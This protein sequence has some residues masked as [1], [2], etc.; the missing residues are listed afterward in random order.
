M[1]K[2]GGGYEGFCVDVLKEL[3]KSLSNFRYNISEL[4][5]QKVGQ[6]GKTSVWDD[7]ITELK[8]GVSTTLN[9]LKYGPP[10]IRL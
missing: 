8:V 10:N 9:S 4:D 5:E 2:L 7:I 3:S 6:N 1:R